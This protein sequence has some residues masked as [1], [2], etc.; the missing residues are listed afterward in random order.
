MA[1]A[2]LR[3]RLLRAGAEFL[4]QGILQTP[5]VQSLLQQ[6]TSLGLLF[7]GKKEE[8]PPWK[9]QGV[10]SSLLDDLFVLGHLGWDRATGPG[11][12]QGA[13]TGIQGSGTRIQGSG[14]WIQGSGTWI[15]DSGFGEQGCGFRDT[16]LGL[17]DRD[18]GSRDMDLGS[19][20]MDLRITRSAARVALPG[21]VGPQHPHGKPSGICA[22]GEEGML[23][24]QPS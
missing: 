16:D 3:L 17:R 11:A 5:L 9:T 23:P 8:I 12:S 4:G 19:R 14:T 1:V 2:K 18:S 13:G 15:R 7:G 22:R 10:K 20:D 6:E 21:S 24:S